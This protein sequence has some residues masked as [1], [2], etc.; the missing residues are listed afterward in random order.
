MSQ[1]LV[2][3]YLHVVF[4]TKERRPFLQDPI[5][6]G[7]MHGYL[8]GICEKQK[9]LSIAI[10]G[11][12]DHVHILCRLGKTL[13]V[14]ALIKALK[15]SSS[16]WIKS[17]FKNQESFHWQNGYGAFSVSPSHVSGLVQYIQNQDEHHRRESF[18]DEFRRLLKKY[19]VEY[20]E[21]Y[22]WD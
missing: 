2:Q 10:N 14:S 7:R 11:V 18:Q 21:R 20:D 16:I 6:R 19:G 9:S 13:D 1:S 22:V 8:Q 12:E 3:I 17:E 5:I 15:Q 4:S